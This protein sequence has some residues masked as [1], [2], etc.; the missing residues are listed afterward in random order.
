MSSYLNRHFWTHKKLKQIRPNKTVA[1]NAELL[2]VPESVIRY[3]CARYGI[4]YKRLWSSKE[5]RRQAY[6]LYDRG[7][8]ISEIAKHLGRSNQVIHYWL[9]TRNTKNT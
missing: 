3:A 6:R 5:K 1:E 2:G 4:P 7:K 9:R 8:T